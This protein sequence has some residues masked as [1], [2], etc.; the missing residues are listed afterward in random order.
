MPILWRLRDRKEVG[1]GPG[2][3]LEVGG[4]SQ[5]PQHPCG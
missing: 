4:I 2:E 1:W 3:E 5:S